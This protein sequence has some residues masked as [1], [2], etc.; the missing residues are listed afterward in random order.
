MFFDTSGAIVNGD[1]Y[2]IAID[3]PLNHTDAAVM[4]AVANSSFAIKFYDAVCS[5]RLYAGRLRFITQYVNRFPLPRLT[6]LERQR[7]GEL[8]W[9]LCSPETSA[10]DRDTI[11]ARIDTLVWDALRLGEVARGEPDL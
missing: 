2:W 5:N 9:K 3:S 10:L 11:E 4:L 7:F 8:V 1:C 6:E